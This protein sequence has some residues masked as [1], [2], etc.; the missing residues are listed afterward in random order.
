MAQEALPEAE[1]V[2]LG[3]ENVEEGGLVACKNCRHL[4]PRTMM[5]LYCGSPILFREPRTVE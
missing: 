4:V 3:E 2:Q 1:V 5:C